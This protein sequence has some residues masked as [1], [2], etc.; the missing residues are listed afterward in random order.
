MKLGFLM[1]AVKQR[2]VNCTSHYEKQTHP[3]SLLTLAP[4][5][6]SAI[7]TGNCLWCQQAVLKDLL[8]CSKNILV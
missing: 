5:Y 7:S 3:S 1:P 4:Y 6:C 8:M 2:L